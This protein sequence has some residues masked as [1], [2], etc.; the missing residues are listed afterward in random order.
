M[1]P[2]LG[3]PGPHHIRPHVRAELGLDQV[4]VGRGR[5][6]AV[7]APGQPVPAAGQAPDNHRHREAQRPARLEHPP[8]LR[9]RVDRVAD[10]LQRVRV[11]DQIER[12]V[13]VRQGVQVHLRVRAERVPP[14]RPED[15]R[16]GPG[17]VDFQHGQVAADP[18][19]RRG[20]QGRGRAQRRPQRVGQ[21]RRAQV[22][23]AP[24]A[25]LAL[26]AVDVRALVRGQLPV[27][28]QFIPQDV[29]GGER[30]PAAH[31]A[32]HG[33]PL[34]SVVPGA[35]GRPAILGDGGGG[36][37]PTAPATRPPGPHPAARISDP[38]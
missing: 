10:V 37:N 36:V 29:A 3:E 4:V 5:R 16:E 2:H 15:R 24:V 26:L 25:G 34:P 1:Q 32:L 28:D 17:L 38:V 35:T 19:D 8:A 27:A 30:R 9:Q 6:V 33:R 20:A 12:A 31:P 14:E 21:G 18:G 23:P 7:V 11:D 13:G 22:G